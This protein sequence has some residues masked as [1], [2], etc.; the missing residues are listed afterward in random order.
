MKLKEPKKYITIFLLAVALIIIYKT[1]D[2]FGVILE[3][4]SKFFNLIAPF[5]TG[6][7]IA[8]VLRL[9]CQKVERLLRKV[10]IKPLKKYRRS[11]SVLFVFIA[12]F[13][14][15][16]LI[17][18]AII[19]QLIDSLS[20]FIEQLPEMANS[21][22]QWILSLGILPENS[23]GITEIL[24]KNVLTI[25]QLVKMFDVE[26]LNK[27]AKGVMSFGSS[28]MNIF[29]GLIVSI[30]MLLDRINIKKA[31]HRLCKAY[32][33]KKLNHSVHFYGKMIIDFIYK[34]IGCQVLDACI[35]FVLC[36]IVLSI[37][38]NEYAA[39]IA[40][41]VGSFNL[42]PY[43]GAIIAVFIAGLITLVTNGFISAVVLAIV[44][45][46][47]QQL[48]ANIIQPRLIS[49]SLSIEPLMV[50]F[51]VTVGGGLF[52]V[53]GMFV[54]VPAVALIKNIL[55]SALDKRDQMKKT[56]MQNNN[57]GE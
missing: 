51:G 7:A 10:K 23:P 54:G 1:F 32:L 4:L 11:F 55:I 33:P 57:G 53:I 25:N 40:L 47:I 15:I 45:I 29:I 3:A 6:F 36:L 5:L 8:F 52:G 12:L 41:M 19:P 31:L 46:V 17:M 34:Y 14:A 43:F 9:P 21:L 56:A 38:R 30:Y 35:V 37:M 27:Y 18:F 39:V 13:A 42:I 48:D 49:N 24:N 28:L 16:V 50:I 44:L 20:R 26:N 22:N 2:N